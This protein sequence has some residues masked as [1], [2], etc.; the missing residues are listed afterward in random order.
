MKLPATMTATLE[1]TRK[2]MLEHFKTK[3]LL[4]IAIVFA[5]VFILLSYYGGAITGQSDPDDPSY[6]E[7]PNKVMSMV[8]S[9]S[10]LFPPIMAIA[11]S[12]DSI[13]GERTRNSMYLLVSKPIHR[14]SIYLGK[15][16]GAFLSISVVYVGVMTM[17]YFLVMGLSGEAAS[18]SDFLDAYGAVGVTLY[19]LACWI[20]FFMLLS[21]VF[22][23]TSTTLIVAVL[24][25]LFV[26][27]L[28]SQAGL[29]YYLV[30]AEDS[31]RPINVNI[32]VTNA[33]MGESDPTINDVIFYTYPN[34]GNH[35]VSYLLQNSTGLVEAGYLSTGMST[36]VFFDLDPDMY[37]W[38]AFDITEDEAKPIETGLFLIDGNH[39]YFQILNVEG[40]EDNDFQ[41]S[42][43]HKS[44][45]QL[46]DVDILITD[47]EG[48]DIVNE[49][50]VPATYTVKDLDEGSY[51]YTVSKN[52]TVLVSHRFHSYGDNMGGIFGGGM[53]E[54]DWPDYVKIPYMVNPDNC[55]GTNQ[56]LLQDDYNGIISLNEGLMGLTFFFILS[57]LAGILLFE[58]I[59][60]D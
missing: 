27:S 45:G 17:G 47:E 24:M 38:K 10:S 31:D 57:G 9:F 2:E 26:L 25:W 43:S 6:E 50:N 30:T 34:D 3:R 49:T 18:G 21:T 19:T 37:Q 53:D 4:I 28:I 32:Q 58:R 13:V 15:F 42:I 33:L 56:E 7:G 59:Q 44:S 20:F 5:A 40:S 46:M 12:H 23:T 1:V 41:F 16:L 48:K 29:I 14:R 60:V 55:G 35:Q 36:T 54:D 22:K 11:L 52:G 8:M 39:T 51:N